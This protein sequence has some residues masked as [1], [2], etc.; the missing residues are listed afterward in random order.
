MII[1]VDT[2]GGQHA[3]TQAAGHHVTD[4]VERASLQRIDQPGNFLLC[5][6]FGTRTENLVAHTVALGQQQHV[7]FRQIRR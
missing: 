7:F 3:D 6:Q 2:G 4:G 5:R 1:V